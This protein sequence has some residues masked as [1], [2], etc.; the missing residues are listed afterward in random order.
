MNIDN[1][2]DELEKLNNHYHIGIGDYIVYFRNANYS[3]LKGIQKNLGSS[4]KYIFKIEKFSNDNKYVWLK[5]I[6][7]SG[8]D[9]FKTETENVINIEVFHDY[10]FL[11]P[12]I[13]NKKTLDKY[14]FVRR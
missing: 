8:N 1:F 5:N 7:E 6:I 3:V 2:I 12:N 9:L 11:T 13:F 4:K 14:Y 10:G